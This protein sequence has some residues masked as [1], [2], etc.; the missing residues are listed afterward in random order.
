MREKLLECGQILR[1]GKEKISLGFKKAEDNPWTKVVETIHEGD[2]VDCKIVRLL[3]FGAFAEIIPGVDGLIHISQIA[4]KRIAKPADVLELGQEVQAKVVDINMETQKIGL[5]M[6][7][8]IEET[9]VAEEVPAQETEATEVA[10]EASSE[11]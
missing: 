7:A 3:P 1:Q 9:E 2:V 11:E 4:N 8:L 6:R 5:S 10:E